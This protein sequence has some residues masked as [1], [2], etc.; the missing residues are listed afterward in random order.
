MKKF[1]GKKILLPMLA[2]MLAIPMAIGLSACG[3]SGQTPPDMTTLSGFATAFNTSTNFVITIV[4]DE[5]GF[6]GTTTVTVNDNSVMVVIDADDWSEEM[7]AWRN[8]DEF[9]MYQRDGIRGH[10]EQIGWNEWEY[11]VIP[12]GAMGL[13]WSDVLSELAQRSTFAG[14]LGAD[15]HATGEGE[16]K[17]LEDTVVSE[18]EG[19]WGED[20]VEERWTSSVTLLEGATLLHTGNVV[21]IEGTSVSEDR[22]YIDGVLEWE[23]SF[24]SEGIFTITLGNAPVITRPVIV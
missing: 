8:G 4:S 14:T 20:G 24:T 18:T 15:W 1:L 13:T 3:G 6:V 11:D 9:I 22:D 23:G 2:L 5:D 16:F 17:L 19:T 21:V 10:D 7:I 12:F